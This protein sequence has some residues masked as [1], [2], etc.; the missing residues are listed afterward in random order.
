MIGASALALL[1]ACGADDEPNTKSVAAVEKSLD[2]MKIED[3][4]LPKLKF[5]AKDYG[6]TA[7]VLAALKLDGEANDLISFADSSTKNGG[8]VFSD[9]SI[10]PKSEDGPALIAKTMTFDGLNMT[11]E[12]PSFDRLILSDMS[13]VDEEESVNLSIGDISIVEPNAAASQFFASLIQGEEPEDVPPLSEWAFD[14]LSLNNLKL[15]AS[16]DDEG[17]FSATIG[18][19]TIASLADAV[20]GNTLF[21]D[22]KVDF[23]MPEA[24]DFPIVGSLNLGKMSVSNLQASFL[25]NLS[26]ASSDMEKF[27]ELN[28]KMIEGYSSPIEQG[29][30]QSFVEGLALDVSGLSFSMPKAATK[31]V[32]DA[33][34][35]AT[36]VVS[37]KTVFKV[38]ADAEAGQ[39]GAQLAQGLAMLDYSDLEFSIGAKASY[40]PETTKTTYSDYVIDMKDGFSLS[41]NGGA[42]DLLDAVKSM[43]SMG[44]DGPDMDALGKIKLSDLELSLEDKSLLDRAFKVAAGMQGMEPDQLKSMASG[45]LAMGTMQASQSGVDMELV[46]QTVNALTTFIEDS[47]TL[48]IKLAPE[49]P[50]SMSDFEDASAM[51]VEAL[52]FSAETK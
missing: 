23:D 21:S 19:L 32:R 46:N 30:D 2:S 3:M 25:E 40:D 36:A 50:I 51:T 44:E 27:A 9:V 48:T 8:A 37:P 43:S 14:R 34:G 16:P 12:G 20:A 13:L 22:F 47:G 31:V 1:A 52:G 38:K 33:D 42:F 49:A 39:L 17:S 11:D 10:K 24:G 15:S 26:E 28:S 45:F 4:K 18:E 35:I 41:M 6:Q 7:E 29:F 5:E